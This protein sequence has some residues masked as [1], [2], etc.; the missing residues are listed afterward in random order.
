M[1]DEQIAEQIRKAV[2]SHGRTTLYSDD[3]WERIVQRIESRAPTSP[4]VEPE[5]ETVVMWRDVDP[6][7]VT[8]PEAYPAVPVELTRP[9]RSRVAWKRVRLAALAA[10]ICLL[11]V[12]VPIGLGLANR[13]ER[14]AP[15]TVPTTA[16]PTTTTTPTTTAPSTT[17]PPSTIVTSPSTVGPSTATPGTTQPATGPNR[18]QVHNITFH[19][20]EA[21][22]IAPPDESLRRIMAFV[23][24]ATCPGRGGCYPYDEVA[25]FLFGFEFGIDELAP[26]RCFTN[27]KAADSPPTL[28]ASGFRPVAERTAE[29]RQWSVTCQGVSEIHSAW[30]LPVSHIA[31]FEQCHGRGVEDV[32][33]TAEVAD[34][35]PSNLKSDR[36]MLDQFHRKAG[37]CRSS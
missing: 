16:P 9:A 19:L 14:I 7:A 23:P 20:P 31:F 29:W 5:E 35:P 26:T 1:N 33:A 17:T 30:L 2:E 11:I 21:W 15:A 13:R 36:P 34:G 25:D 27:S 6:G 22:Q 32:V 28:L 10:A 3:A 24:N 4:T 12:A 8:P 37:Q 18:V